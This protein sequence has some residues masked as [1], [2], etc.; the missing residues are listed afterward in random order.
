MVGR[1]CTFIRANGRP[2]RATPLREEP[3]C[4]WHAPETAEE[5]AEA[6]RL[7]GL[8]RRRKKTVSAVYGFGGLRTVEDNQ[9]LLETAAVETLSLENSISRNRALASYASIGAKLIEVGDFEERLATLEAATRPRP[10]S[11]DHDFDDEL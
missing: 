5:A 3:F 1:A 4:F 8:H 2:C 9:A 7:G 6:R 10:D 11:V